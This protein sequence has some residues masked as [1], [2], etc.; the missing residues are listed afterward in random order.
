VAHPVDNLPLR[1]LVDLA[2]SYLQPAEI[3]QLMA[4]LGSADG[5]TA[6][7]AVIRNFIKTAG[8]GRSELAGLVETQATTEVDM[9]RLGMQQG[10]TGGG[11]GGRVGPRA[12][13]NPSVTISPEVPITKKMRKAID[14]QAA[15]Y[16]EKVAMS[17]LA[18]NPKVA[19][20]IKSGQAAAESIGIPS[21]LEATQIVKAPAESLASTAIVKY[22]RPPI[23]VH[24]ELATLVAGGS[25]EGITTPAGYAQHIREM[26]NPQKYPPMN[27][28][29]ELAVRGKSELA[30]TGG[31]GVR[32]GA[33]EPVQTPGRPIRGAGGQKL[34]GYAGEQVGP[35]SSLAG[36]VGAEEEV[37]AAKGASK[38]FSK[39]GLMGVLGKAG[40]FV[41][42]AFGVLT[43]IQLAQLLEGASTGLGEKQRVENY[44]DNVEGGNKLMQGQML[45]EEQNLN[46]LLRASHQRNQ[47][48][49]HVA[50]QDEVYNQ[51]SLDQ[52]LQGKRQNIAAM[53]STYSPGPMEMMA[54]M[55]QLSG[56]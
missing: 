38:L 23:P 22:D 49:G 29:K 10:A 42:P 12:L 41:G 9:A 51:S 46:G 32:V 20:S 2:S 28:G 7:E 37:A 43:A 17:K 39:A 31:P 27:F 21:K 56:V 30:T 44:L 53:A 8:G 25:S 52:L 35:P 26:N 15:A 6:K 13:R 55:R 18:A 48:L 34:L 4:Q 50:A 1:E 11:R 5:V 24:S 16:E 3:E 40:K 14:A 19:N 54:A 33:G 36:L 45:S 47:V